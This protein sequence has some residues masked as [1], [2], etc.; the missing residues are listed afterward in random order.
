MAI[1]RTETQVTWDTGSNSKS[2]A[3]SSNAT[4][5]VVTLDQTCFAAQAHIYADNG[6]TPASGDV[7][8][9]YLLQTGGDPIGTGSDVYDN[10]NAAHALFLV[11]INTNLAD[12]A[13]ATVQLPLPQKGMNFYGVNQSS[14]RAITIGV[15]I[16]E[17]RG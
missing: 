4:S 9:V 8:D 3:S 10:S 13:Q 16:T 14:G 6:G 12:P 7:L 2:I 5:D 1:T 11:S 17:Q 15:T